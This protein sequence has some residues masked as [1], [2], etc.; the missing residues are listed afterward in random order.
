[1]AKATTKRAVSNRGNARHDDGKYGEVLYSFSYEMDDLNYFNAAGLVG[2]NRMQQILTGSSMVLLLLI[3]GSLYDREHP[4]YPVAIA[5]FILFL[6][7]SIASQNWTRIRDRYVSRSSLTQLGGTDRHVVV[8][9]EAMIVEGPDDT[10]S[11]YPLSEFKKLA[12]DSDGALAKFGRRRYVYIPRKALSET[13]YR[14]LTK[15]LREQRG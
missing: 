9:A 11:S 10:V 5:A 12:E 4:L 2:S 7:L 1:M 14:S 3:I 8:T 6:A 13:R 15:M